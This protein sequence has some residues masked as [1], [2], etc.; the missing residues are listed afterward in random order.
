M[1]QA[2]RHMLSQIILGMPQP[3][4][5]YPGMMLPLPG[6][7]MTIAQEYESKAL[8]MLPAV[9]ERNPNLKNQV[10]QIIFDYIEKMVG[11]ERTPKITGMLVEL[12]IIQ[13]QMYMSR[14]VNLKK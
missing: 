3:G 2:Q 14:Y 4:M 12:P 13:I 10:S 7:P 6:M 1:P 5:L 9:Q 8:R 11:K